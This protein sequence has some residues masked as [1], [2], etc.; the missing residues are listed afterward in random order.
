MICSTFGHGFSGNNIS[1]DYFGTNKIIDDLKK[2]KTF[3]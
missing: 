1:H 3:E 2:Y